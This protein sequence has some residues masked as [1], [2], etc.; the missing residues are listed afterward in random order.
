MRLPILSAAFAALC[1]ALPA[2]AQKIQ[3]FGG[4]GER[5]QTSQLFFGENVMGGMQFVWTPPVWK[6]SYNGQFDMLK[7]KLHRLGK[8]WW[9]TFNTTADVEFGGTK[10]P[11]GCYV[12]GLECSKDGK[13]SLALL[14]AT[15]AMKQGAM[16]FP[17]AEDG[18]M[19]WKPEILVP[20]TLNKDSTKES[21]EKMAMTLKFDAADLAKGSF[22]FAWGTH[23]LTAPVAV[24]LPKSEPAKKE[25]AKK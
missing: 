7:G 17:V 1:F 22:T 14:D 23:T 11:A 2:T 12:V 24:M 16:P 20:L 9:T 6:D 19:N 10:V 18:N 15:K 4:D 5:S 13:F 8:D 3:V 21:V 25:P